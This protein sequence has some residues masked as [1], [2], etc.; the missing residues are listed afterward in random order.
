MW[1]LFHFNENTETL[2]S[3]VTCITQVVTLL[4]YGKSEVLEVFKNMLHTGLYWVLFPIEDLRQAVETAKRILTKEKID[5]KLADQS[6][7]TPCMNIKGGYISKKVT[8]DMQDSLDDKIDRLMSMV[9]K[10]TAQDDNQ[11]KPF[12]PNNIK[13]NREYNQEICMITII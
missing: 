4:G 2:D 3:Y 6:S 1:R 11:N 8:F 10:L 12:K 5:R 13:A 9:S 7:S